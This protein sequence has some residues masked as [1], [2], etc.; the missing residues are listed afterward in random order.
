MIA[1]V[2][3]AGEGTRLRPLTY[4]LPKPL[5]PIA[6]RPVLEYT[7]LN[8][9]KHGIHEV[10]INLSSTNKIIREYFKEGSALGLKIHYSLEK[11]ILG[12]AGGVKNAEHFFQTDPDPN[13]LI[14]SGD[15]LTDINFS[16]FIKFHKEKKAVGSIAV[17]QV[18]SRFEYGVT[19]LKKESRIEKFI[20][21]PSWGDLF[22][23]FVNTGIYLFNKEVLREIPKNKF[24][25]FGHQLL[26]KLLLEKKSLYGF[27][28][29]EFWTDIGTLSEYRRAQAIVLDKK[30]ET[31]PK[32]KEI[33]PG[34]WVGKTTK[35]PRSIKLESPC[36]I[37]EHCVI[38]ENAK[39]G[40]HTF[41][42]NHCKIGQKSVI[43][44]SILWDGSRVSNRV[45]L[46]DCIVTTERVIPPD[47]SISGG[48]VL[49]EKI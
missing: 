1:M 12:T 16:K 20:E 46:E 29:N 42:G 2:M 5:V 37:G 19:L 25:D 26:P 11:N 9:K 4:V 3:C 14:V 45:K 39:I 32:G 49:D 44:Q 24:Y 31:R 41:I 33:R 34:I 27:K 28:F 30:I 48:L 23:N 36:S 18:D 15:N 35:L 47:I 13:I 10:V 6:N 7:L 22:S 8:L 17:T 21:K 40:S 43:L 38:E